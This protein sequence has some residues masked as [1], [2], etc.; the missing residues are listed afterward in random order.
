M[1]AELTANP[2]LDTSMSIPEMRSA[3]EAFYARM[4]A[5]HP[6]LVDI[7]NRSIQGKNGLIPIRIYRSR[8][9]STRPLP[10]FVFFHGGGSMMGS[11]DS[12]D[13]VCQE[14]CKASGCLLI[15]V[16]YHLAPEHAFA[17]AVDDCYD[18][19]VWAHRNAEG[20]GGDPRRLAVGGESGGG[21]LAAIVTQLAR[22]RG[23]PPLAFQLLIYPYV[24]SRGES[25]SMREFATGY[26][27]EAVTLEWILDLNFK[28][29][30]V[31]KDWRVAPIWAADFSGLPPAL[32]ITAGVDILRDDAEE[33]ARCLRKAGVAV[34]LSRY[35]ETIH[36]F[37][38]MA[39]EIE[40][41]RTAIAECGR[42]LRTALGA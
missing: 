31:L 21:G 26:F 20:L 16:A 34:D 2:F 5:G 14:L 41:G 25:R 23:G 30:S 37:V 1:L 36:G 29:R 32:I 8:E 40:A 35:D 19:A 9:N 13:A 15:S 42:K 17:V 3:F 7:D 11:L 10:V 22:E 4:Y 6:Q 27:F 24:G 18:C 28:D 33:Y 12:F 39:G 38:A